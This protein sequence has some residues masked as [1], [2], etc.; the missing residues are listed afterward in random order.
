[1]DLSLTTNIFPT[2][3]WQLV[4]DSDLNAIVWNHQGDGIIINKNLV[5]KE[6]LS[7]NGSKATSFS[8]FEHQL[9]LYG[10]QKSEGFND[11]EAN[12]YH[13]FHPN[14][15]KNQS[16]LL[17]LLRKYSQIS[18]PSVKDELQDDLTERW[19][20]HRDL[21]DSGDDTRDANRHPGESFSVGLSNGVFLTILWN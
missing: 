9:I 18:R 11:D 6:V 20:D 13:Y 16:E 17:P 5:E 21:D 14:F 4:D 10:F 2:K 3:L 19:R 8:N 15:K 7:L 1:M 12:I